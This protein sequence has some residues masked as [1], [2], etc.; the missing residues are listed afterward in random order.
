LPGISVVEYDISDNGKEVVYSTRPPGKP[1]Q[2]WLADLERSLAPNLIASTGESLPHFGTD[3]QLVFQFPEGNKHFVGRMNKD[4][5]ARTRVSAHPVAGV[6][7]ISPDR[8]WIAA[9]APPLDGGDPAT[10]GIAVA[11]GATRRIC[12]AYCPATWTP[13]GKYLYLGFER[14][15]HESPGKT[16]VVPVPPGQ[17]LPELPAAGIRN[18]EDGQTFPGARIIE[19][20]EISPG[21]YPSFAY[22]KTTVLS[23]LFRIPLRNR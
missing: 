11:D 2:L 21:P 16:L 14:P 20:S 10:I 12:A 15:S 18:L 17:T 4:G 13:D 23:N 8:R 5:S 19:A 22:V 6:L 7:G 1:S 9:V 3:D